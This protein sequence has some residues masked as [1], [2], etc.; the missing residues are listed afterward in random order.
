MFSDA[1]ND[2]LKALIQQQQYHSSV[3]ALGGLLS[4]SKPGRPIRERLDER[5]KNAEQ[6]LV[7]LHRLMDLVES[8]PT[9]MTD[10]DLSTLVNL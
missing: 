10:A 4:G 6:E 2:A 1:K 8:M 9:D 3:S 5:I 7:R